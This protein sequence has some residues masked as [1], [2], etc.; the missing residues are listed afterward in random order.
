MREPG[1][2]GVHGVHALQHAILVL[3]PEQEAIQVVSHV[4][5]VHLKLGI[6][7]VSFKCYDKALVKSFQICHFS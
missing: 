6:V 1:Q 7:T 5:A 2:L 3:E 4:Q